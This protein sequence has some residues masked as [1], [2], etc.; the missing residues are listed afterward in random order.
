M[1]D[2][3]WTE[4][5]QKTEEWNNVWADVRTQFYSSDALDELFIV[6]K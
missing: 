2:K 1:G 6:I 5:K 4:H 3:S